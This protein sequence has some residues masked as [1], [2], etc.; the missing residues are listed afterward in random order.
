MDEPSGKVRREGND[1][2]KVIASRA[3]SVRAGLET[4]RSAHADAAW[5]CRCVADV[6]DASFP[7]CSC[8]TTCPG[9]SRAQ[10]LVDGVTG[11]AV[12]RLDTADNVPP[13][14]GRVALDAVTDLPTA[15][16]FSGCDVPTVPVSGASRRGPMDRRRSSST[17]WPSWRCGDR[18]PHERCT[19]GVLAASTMSSTTT[20]PTEAAAARPPPTVR[21]VGDGDQDD[22]SVPICGA[23]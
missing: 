3:G 5:R 1:Q 8:R 14:S 21:S 6:R 16:G 4:C 7:D 12:V 22:A 2:P 13:L 23:F 20:K 10:R 17:T 19:N 18:S 9:R 11:P 15:V